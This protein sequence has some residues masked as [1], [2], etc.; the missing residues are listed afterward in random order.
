MEKSDG[1][2][3]GFKNVRVKKKRVRVKKKRMKEEILEGEY[4]FII[5]TLGVV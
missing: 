3:G 4:N 2:G 1:G 5:I